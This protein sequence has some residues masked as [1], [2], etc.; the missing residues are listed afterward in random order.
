MNFKPILFSTPMVQAIEQQRKTQTR[1]AKGL[2]EINKNPDEWVF[3][4]YAIRGEGS[5]I[6]NIPSITNLMS[7]VNINTKERV[8]IPYAYNIYD[9]LWVRETFY[10]N[11]AS[12]IAGTFYY[13]ALITS[14]WD[15]KWKPSIFMPKEACRLFL[16][17]KAIRVE[18]LQGISEN[19]AIA[20]G[21]FY[22]KIFNAYECYLCGKKFPIGNDT[23]C[24]DGFFDNAFESFRSLWKSINTKKSTWESNPWVWVIEFEKIDKPEKFNI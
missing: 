5:S 3:N 1:R 22:N 4:G 24:E 12:Q 10:K 2:E 11:T 6:S 14:G 13:K 9:I 18:R 16:Q 7:F 23:F 21:V 19:N 15:L 17:I 8:H 20:E